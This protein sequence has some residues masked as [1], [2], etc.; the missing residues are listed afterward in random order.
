M[1]PKFKTRDVAKILYTNF[2]KR[3]QEC[4]NAAAINIVQGCIASCDAMCVYYLGKRHSGDNHNQAVILFKSIK[5]TDEYHTNANRILRILRMKNMA[6]YEERLIY[7]SEAEKLFK[8]YG[9]FLKFVKRK[10]PGS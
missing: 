1:T 8:D 10:W 7:Q 9:R 4:F 6:E 5:S 2:V 3:S